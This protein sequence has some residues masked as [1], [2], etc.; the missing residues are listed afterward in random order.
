MGICMSMTTTSGRSSAALF[1]ASLPFSAKPTTSMPGWLERSAPRPVL[2]SGLSSTSRTRIVRPVVPG[3]ASA[4]LGTTGAEDADLR[5]LDIGLEDSS[6]KLA[7]DLGLQAR[8][9][10]LPHASKRA[11]SDAR[12]A[13]PGRAP[14]VPVDP[15]GRPRRK[16]SPEPPTASELRSSP[17]F[18]PP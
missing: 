8:T 17:A 11:F 15:H 18:V 3:S 16:A 5:T 10:R 12:P 1:D 9:Q 13:E 14:G 7:H 2:N 4:L 6:L